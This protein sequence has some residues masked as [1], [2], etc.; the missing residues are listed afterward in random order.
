LLQSQAKVEAWCERLIAQYPA[1][2]VSWSA[3]LTLA[4]VIRAQ[5]PQRAAALIEAA[6][7]QRPDAAE[8]PELQMQLADFRLGSQDYAAAAAAY[9]EIAQRWPESP[10]V[11]PAL[12]NA[13]RALISDELTNWNPEHAAVAPRT[14]DRRARIDANLERLMAQAATTDPEALAGSMLDVINYYAMRP[15]WNDGARA[16]A[17]ERIVEIARQMQSLSPGTLATLRAK[18][19]L[20]YHTRAADP[21]VAVVTLKEILAQT[22]QMGKES[23]ELDTLSALGRVLADAGESVQARAVFDELLT[24]KLDP[25]FEGEIRMV[26]AFADPSEGFAVGLAELEEVAADARYPD[27]VRSSALFAQALHERQTARSDRA[28]A[29]LDTLQQLYPR[30]VNAHSADVL[31]E[32]INQ[33]LAH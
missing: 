9:E 21:Q 14:I 4:S 16:G 22:R 28:L 19:D 24:H 7:Q 20:T 29:I 23:L 13:N 27:E 26:R 31:R 17:H 18:I 25:M 15:W 32:E 10:Q 33:S 5:D 11:T 12:Q 6:I 30:T 3:R 2:P 1:A 8:A